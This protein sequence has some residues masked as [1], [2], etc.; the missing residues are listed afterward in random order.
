MV[1]VEVKIFVGSV[2][3]PAIGGWITLP[4]EK[5]A[6]ETKIK[7]LKIGEYIISDYQTEL[8]VEIGEYQSPYQVNE[9]LQLLLAYEQEGK[10][11]L[12]LSA[13]QLRDEDVEGT[14]RFLAKG[15]YRYFENVEDTESLGESVARSGELG[16]LFMNE[17]VLE[18]LDFEKIGN[19]YECNGCR[20]YPQLKTAIMETRPQA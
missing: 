8:P 17:K 7:E 4:M 18:Y 12:F 15:N 16:V 2:I 14:I 3:S 10:L 1:K 13:Y 5:E 9:F 11:K 6:L 20:I 19:D